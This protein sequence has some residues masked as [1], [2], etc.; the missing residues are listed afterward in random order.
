MG[1]MEAAAV[2][3][4]GLIYLHLRLVGFQSPGR[5]DRFSEPIQEYG[6]SHDQ[7]ELS[8]LLRLGVVHSYIAFPLGIDE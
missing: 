2:R 7:Y 1:A 6:V 8:H 3:I 5:Q 4:E